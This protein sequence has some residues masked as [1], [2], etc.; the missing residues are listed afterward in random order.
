MLF[1]FE[2]NNI[3]KPQMD[4]MS[5]LFLSFEKNNIIEQNMDDISFLLFFFEKNNIIKQIKIIFTLRLGLA[6]VWAQGNY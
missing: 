5:F 1:F 6:T 4:G 3:I 2:K